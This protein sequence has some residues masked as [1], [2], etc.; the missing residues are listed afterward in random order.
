[1]AIDAYAGLAPSVMALCPQ[2]GV[3][4]TIRNVVAAAELGFAES[5][6]RT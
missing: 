1:V 2:Y 4:A 5:H 3:N 6:S